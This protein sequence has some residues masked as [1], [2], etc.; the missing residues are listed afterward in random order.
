M[1]LQSFPFLIFS[2]R[3]KRH[4]NFTLSVTLDL[5]FLCVILSL[6]QKIGLDIEVMLTVQQKYVRE[7]MWT[8]V[9][10]VNIAL[11][12]LWI[13]KEQPEFGNMLLFI[14]FHFFN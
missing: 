4:H 12:D 6:T 3:R 9:V 5:V 10:M 2:T 13:I 14:L 7:N 1:F 11:V 8:P